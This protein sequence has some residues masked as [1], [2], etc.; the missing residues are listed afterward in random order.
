MLN[1]VPY[2]KA[3]FGSKLGNREGQGMVEYVLI[4]ALIAIAVIAALTLLGP[5]ISQ[6]FTDIG[7]ELPAAAE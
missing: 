7:E 4:I 6:V 5:Q 1:Y 3:M 2:F